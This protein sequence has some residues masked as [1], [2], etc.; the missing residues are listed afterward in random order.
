MVEILNVW[1]FSIKSFLYQ[2]RG[3]L[4]QIFLLCRECV[5]IEDYCQIPEYHIPTNIPLL[6]YAWLTENR[7]TF[8]HSLLIYKVIRGKKIIQ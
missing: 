8:I 7:W 4:I 1:H 6:D 2:E 3:S 5:L